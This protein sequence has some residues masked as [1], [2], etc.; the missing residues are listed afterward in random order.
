MKDEH[1]K[2]VCQRRSPEQRFADQPE[3]IGEFGEP[4]ESALQHQQFT[5][6]SMVIPESPGSLC[7]KL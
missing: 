1:F 7:F 2:A 6:D 3:V 5:T 4:A